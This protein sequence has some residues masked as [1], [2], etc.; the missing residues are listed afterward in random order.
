MSTENVIDSLKLAVDNR[1][2]TVDVLN[3]VLPNGKPYDMEGQLWDYKVKMPVLGTDPAE[4]DKQAHR[5]AIGELVKDAVAFHNAFGGYIIFGISDKG[6]N[7]LVGVGDTF[8][9]AEFNKSVQRYAGTSIE[10]FYNNLDFSHP[11]LSRPLTIGLLLIPRRAVGAPPVKML[12]KGPEKS[13]GKLVFRDEVYVR[14]RDECR[15]AANTHEDWKFLH[16]DRLPPE[17]VAGSMAVPVQ[18]HLPARDD[19]LIAFVGR[20]QQLASLRQWIGD[21]RS[22]VRLVTGIGGLGKTTLAYRFAEEVA[23]T[24]A[25]QVEAVIWLTAKAQTF[26]ALRGKMVPTSRVDFSDLS[27]LFNAILKYLHFELPVSEDEPSLAEITD[28]LVEGLLII[29]SLIIVDDLDTLMP[30]EQKEAVSALNSLALRTVG[31][32]Q[33]PSRVL[34][35]SRIDQGLP[36]TAIVKIRGLER[37]AFDTHLGNL[38]VAFGIAP[39][40]GNDLDDVFEASSGSPL[41]AAS[42]VRLVKLGEDRREVVEKWKGADGEEVR[43]FAFE[44]ELVRLSAIQSRVLYAV[45]LLGE[46]NLNDIAEVLELPARTVRDRVSEL[47]AYHLISTITRTHGDSAISVPSELQ[48]VID[49]IKD[50]LGAMA[51]TVEAA[52]A[53]AHEKSGNQDRQVGAGIRTI[54]RLWTA[55]QQNEALIVAQELSEKFPGNGDAASILGSAYL[56]LRPSKYRDADRELDRAVKLG[57]TKSELLPNIIQAKTALED[58]AGL[59]DFTRTRISNE[60]G[61]DISLSAHL[62]ANSQL[63]KIA[64]VRADRKRVAELSIEAV[65]RITAKV[66]RARLEPN[67]FASL[68]SQR[69]DFARSY[70]EAVDLDNP[71]NGD[72]LRVFEAVARLAAADVIILKLLE[73]GVGALEQW[74]KDVERR[75]VADISACKILSRMLAKLE[76]MEQEI[77]GFKRDTSVSSDIASRRRELEYRGGALQAS[78]G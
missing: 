10:C 76:G 35:T 11:G 66:R 14:V 9:C 1:S 27:S 51:Q 48:A 31:R 8:N 16:S 78:I 13:D 44:R 32:E 30:D 34:M 57:S 56:R 62:N 22:P 55:E 42:I 47:Q 6:K 24:G 20:D 18:S 38:C 63:I 41:F 12:R 4:A 43:S 29:P 70:I 17:Q 46:T 77:A 39:F 68:T 60:T 3:L 61:R 26:S 73:K 36:P 54:V 19:D 33:P 58:W 64:R 74:W 53:R 23:D 49:L 69:M 72:R 37:D 7:R 25:G 50:N 15:A 21:P 28:R 67:Y 52:V 59:R 71:Q 45:M 75:P 2:L 5:V 65:E 40:V